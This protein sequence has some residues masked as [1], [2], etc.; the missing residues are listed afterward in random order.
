MKSLLKKELVEVS[1][2]LLTATAFVLVAWHRSV[3]SDREWLLLDSA[4]IE[5]SAWAAGTFG[6]VWGFLQ[7]RAEAWRATSTYLVHRGSGAGGAFRAKVTVGVLSAAWL[8]LGVPWGVALWHRFHSPIGAVIDLRPFL[9]LV[10]LL[11]IGIGTYACAVLG[12]Q[13][14]RNVLLDAAW[15]ILAVATYGVLVELAIWQIASLA[16]LALLAGI[17]LA[18]AVLLLRVASGL[19]RRPRDRETQFTPGQELVISVASVVLLLGLFLCVIGALAQN[20]TADLESH[21]PALV[22]DKSTGR[23]LLAERSAAGPWVLTEDTVS[24][25]RLVI[26]SGGGLFAQAP[27]L[28]DEYE[29]VFHPLGVHGWVEPPE[30]REDAWWSGTWLRRRSAL[31]FGGR[32]DHAYRSHGT[33][34]QVASFLDRAAG[35][36][37]LIWTEPL[38]LGPYYPLWIA[39]DV[40]PPLPEPVPFR[41]S[42]S[43][44]DGQRF[45]ERV[46]ATDY[47]GTYPVLVTDLGD[48]SLWKLDARNSAEPI[49][50]LE[51]PGGDRLR[52]LVP[53]YDP[54]AARTGRFVGRGIPALA[55]DHGTY[56]WSGD[57]FR[58]VVGNE[59]PSGVT[60]SQ[61]IEIAVVRT[62]VGRWDPSAIEVVVE[63]A[64]G[65]GVI[66]QTTLVPSGWES[67]ASIALLHVLALLR[68]PV[69]NLWS[70]SGEH[71]SDSWIAREL[72]LIEPLLNG[73]SRAWLLV[74]QLGLVSWVALL[75]ARRLRARR[76][77]LVVAAAWI[78]LVVV[79]GPLVYVPFR[80]LEP[81]LRATDRLIR[82]ETSTA[83]LLHKA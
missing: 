45:S 64:H 81:R 55:G 17:Q 59:D 35:M 68:M 37:D 47:D 15:T 28:P 7:F 23:V 40:D 79:A 4:H 51:L 73:G 60:L 21:L 36:I 14:R 39:D 77:A 74:L 62:K 27:S 26:G 9:D 71:P 53:L 50:R 33:L 43:R 13:L 12:S 58:M 18:F 44:P 42:Y 20:R 65:G 70:F 80:W 56:V 22:R 11:P 32:P 41:R 2:L 49:T 76:P 1:S 69:T 46:L 67:R 63:D 57:D 19:F 78:G 29:F 61:A 10:W 31:P 6:A 30:K 3:N 83:L 66:A 38:R 8:G 24:G 48:N 75:L 82:A 16:G 52:S 34:F 54:Q 5:I 72:G 25:K